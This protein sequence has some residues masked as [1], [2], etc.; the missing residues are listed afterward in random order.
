M[1]K[2][3]FDQRAALLNA[4]NTKGKAVVPPPKKEQKQEPAKQASKGQGKRRKDAEDEPPPK[5]K[6]DL[7]EEQQKHLQEK[8][9]E[10]RQFYA[11]EE[12]KKLSENKGADASVT[13]VEDK[14]T[15]KPKAISD[16]SDYWKV[17]LGLLPFMPSDNVGA[18]E[19][20]PEDLDPAARLEYLQLF[21]KQLER[22][23]RM[24]FHIFW[25]Q[26]L[27]DPQLSR[28]LDSYLRFCYRSHDLMGADQDA[29]EARAAMAGAQAAEEE[30]YATKEI[31]RRVLQ[32]LVRLSRPQ[33]SSHDYISHDKF[34]QIIYEKH[35]FDV[36]KLIDICTIYGDTNRNT[37]TKMVH[38]IFTHQ[39]LFK[40][41]FNSVVQHMLDGL[42]QCCAPLRNAS[43]GISE[44]NGISLEECLTFLPDI[45]CCFNAIFCFFPEDCVEKLMSGGLEA[46]GPDSSRGS[47]GAAPDLPLADLMVLLHDASCALR[48]TSSEASPDVLDGINK[49]VSRLL[50]CVLAF[51]LAPRKGVGAF[52]ELLEWLKEQC[53][54]TA[55]LADLRR[56][57]LENVAMEWLASGLVDDAQL[58][59]LDEVCGGALLPKEA[60][61]SKQ[62]RPAAA[63]PA[64]GSASRPSAAGTSSSSSSKPRAAAATSG[65]DAA[66]IREVR[67]VVGEGYG[68]GFLLQ[69]LLHYG[70]NVPTLVG[71]ILDNSL[72]PQ[73][74]ALPIGLSIREE[75]AATN[76]AQPSEQPGLSSEDKKWIFAQAGR[77]DAEEI[78]EADEYDDDYDD[79]EGLGVPKLAA[80][81]AGSESEGDDSVDPDAESDEDTGRQQYGQDRGRGGRL[82][83]MGK[84]KQS[85]GPVQGQTI[86]ARRK[87]ANKASVANHNRRDAAA[88]KMGRGMM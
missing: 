18:L 41:E 26:V 17:D 16:I 68:E 12:A 40:D 11:K 31:S 76:S 75:I 74:A 66:K 61:Q 8:E 33:E 48:K 57:G 83:G 14:D 38:S 29:L 80:G 6:K 82:K 52:D 46:E 81:A 10:R 79:A 51:R 37:V 15:R 77:Q 42:L 45:L 19:E 67:E 55:L 4:L 7:E 87:E 86:Q 60:R 62:R 56:H 1:G 28:C 22:L 43:K 58:D 54:R 23:L 72:P 73:L 65:S 20:L 71:A 84:G 69:C 47:S 9:Q 64:S 59:Y 25:S 78:I 27:Y 34:A 63:G 2:Q 24:K 3:A 85:K 21:S 30:E 13:Y 39:S 35:I 53:D 44:A 49:M 36:P 88:R 70:G 32:L 50:S 5:T